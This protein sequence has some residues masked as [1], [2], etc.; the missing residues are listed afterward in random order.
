MFQCVL[1]LIHDIAVQI[2]GSPKRGS[3]FRGFDGEIPDSFRNTKSSPNARLIYVFL[4]LESLGE[5]QVIHFTGSSDWQA[6]AHCS[7]EN[8]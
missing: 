4:N 3:N 6:S 1:D 2:S 5:T 7:F 8:H